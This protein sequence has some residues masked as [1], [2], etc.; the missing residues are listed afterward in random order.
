MHALL[1]NVQYNN[2]LLNLKFI[3]FSLIIINNYYYLQSQNGNKGP[4]IIPIVGDRGDRGVDGPPGAKG[5]P[6]AP[7]HEGAKGTRGHRVN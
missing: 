4:V 1:I 7:G 6:G 5:P 3:L 2:M